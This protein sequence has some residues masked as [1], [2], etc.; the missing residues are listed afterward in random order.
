MRRIA[1]F[2]LVGLTA[3]LVHFLIATGLYRLG[4]ASLFAANAAGFACAFAVSYAGHYFLTF[5]SDAAHGA[6]LL[7][8]ALTAATGFAVN[9]AVLWLS[10]ENLG[11]PGEF[12]LLLAIGLAAIAVYVLSRNF[13]FAGRKAL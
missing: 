8:F 12:A 5:K 10:V 7:K 6:A 2:G 1:T 13:A 9:N 3:S 11:L 4:F